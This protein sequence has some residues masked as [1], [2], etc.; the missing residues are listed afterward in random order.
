MTTAAVPT[1]NFRN[2][3][4]LVDLRIEGSTEIGQGSH[5]PE[6]IGGSY[7]MEWTEYYKDAKT[8]E[9]YKVR[10]SDGV[11]GGHNA[12]LSK[13]EALRSKCYYALLER[14]QASAREGKTE[15]LISRNERVVMNG[16]THAC[17]LESAA[18]KNDGKQ[19]EDGIEGGLV[20]HYHGIPVICDLELQD[21]AL[22]R[23]E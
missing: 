22:P 18:G 12:H 10:C 8:G 11:Y 17:L 23:Q 4:G 2:C 7:S 21:L 19:S 9:V 3:A 1:I 5:S 13:D 6:A 20:G 15:I 16:H 14:F